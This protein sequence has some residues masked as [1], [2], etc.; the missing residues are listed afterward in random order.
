MKGIIFDIK[1]YAIHDGPGIRTTVFFKGCPLNCWWCHNPE[2]R[3]PLPQRIGKSI[4][5]DSL[6][7]KT[8]V[9]GQE[10]TVDEVMKEVEKD[11]LYY[12][13]SGG[14][15]TFS[16]GEPLMQRA[17][18]RALL[19]AAKERELHTTVDT[20]GHVP[21]TAFEGVNG[22]VDLY[23]F[24]LKLLDDQTHMK[25]TGVSNT[26]IL[27]NLEKL[28][29]QGHETEL[30]IP[31]IPGITDTDRNIM[32]T[33]TYISTLPSIPPVHLLP[34][35]KIG[36]GKYE[37]FD[38]ENKLGKLEPQSEHRL[39]QIIKQFQDAGIDAA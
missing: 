37:R 22:W 12:D 1:K 28:L 32:E 2:S 35:N 11:T 24:D 26:L 16:G 8:K 6:N 17:F 19:I 33:I 34:Y 31:L 18:L 3:S 14:G 39:L 27:R 4:Q 13:E 23:L 20:C 9:I 15:V 36:E 29:E 21:Y 25:Y 30:R 5:L 10:M 38:I 7:G